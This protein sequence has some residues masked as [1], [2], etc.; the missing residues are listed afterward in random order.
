VM[1]PMSLIGMGMV[2]LLMWLPTPDCETASCVAQ[3]QNLSTGIVGGLALTA[4]VG[5][6][7]LMYGVGY[8]RRQAR[9]QPPFAVL[10]QVGR[11][12]AGLGLT[13]QF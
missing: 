10:P 13:G 12:F 8:K 11:G 3:Y 6:G 1:L 2:R 9:V 4:S 5:A 7:L